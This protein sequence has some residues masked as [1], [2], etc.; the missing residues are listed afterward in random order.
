MGYE[1]KKGYNS[2]NFMTYN[3]N[4]LFH[5]TK[6]ESTLK[7]LATNSLIFGEYENMNDI[8]ESRREIYD[9][10]LEKEIHL[11]KTLSFTMDKLNRRAF[12]IDPLWGY[13]AEKGN[14][15]CLAFDKEMLI[16]NFNKLKG[17]RRHTNIHY[18]KKFSNA[19][20]GE[21]KLPKIEVENRYK[22]IFFTKSKDWK[23]ENEYRFLI[24]PDVRTLN[25][26]N[27]GDSLVAIIICLPLCS[28]ISEVRETAEYKIL[29]QQTMKPILR[30]TTNLGSKELW[31]IETNEL[32]WPLLGVDYYLDV[33]Y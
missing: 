20:F 14:G 15:V 8:S 5:F 2:K 10:E 9:E 1:I 23:I 31:N 16:K 22:D 12:E 33:K 26:I 19:I 6:F 17:F 25:K 7:I 27:F 28:D 32:L 30:Y 4:M 3:G 13:Y 18:L 21:S 11:Y 29:K 24:R